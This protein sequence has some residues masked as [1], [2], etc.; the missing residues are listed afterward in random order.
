LFLGALIHWNFDFK[1]LDSSHWPLAIS[2]VNGKSKIKGK[3]KAT[4]QSQR[5]HRKVKINTA[6]STATAKSK[7][8]SGRSQIWNHSRSF[9][10]IRG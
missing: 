10:L 7:A 8:K 9:A 3:S 5:Q 1:P 4:P 2:K 6:K